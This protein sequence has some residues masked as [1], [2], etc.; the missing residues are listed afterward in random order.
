MNELVDEMCFRKL[1]GNTDHKFS[2]RFSRVAP[3]KKMIW[4]LRLEEEQSGAR[5]ACRMELYSLKQVQSVNT[6]LKRYYVTS[7]V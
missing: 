2:S 5:E 1:E 7:R 3:S 6:I 4:S